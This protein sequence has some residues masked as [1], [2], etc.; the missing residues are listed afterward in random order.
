MARLMQQHGDSRT[1]ALE[2]LPSG[3][4]LIRFARRCQ[5][6]DAGAAHLVLRAG[7]PSHDLFQD[8]ALRVGY[9]YRLRMPSSHRVSSVL[10]SSDILVL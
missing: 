2:S 3:D 6:D 4:A 5:Q 10:G 7:L 9:R 8:C 1:N